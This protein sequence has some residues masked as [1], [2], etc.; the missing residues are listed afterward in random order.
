MSVKI[1][2]LDQAVDLL[3]EAQFY[4]D[5]PGDADRIASYIA[6]RHGGEG[7]YAGSFALT[8]GERADGIRVFT[9]E[10]MTSASARHIIGEEACRALRK[11]RGPKPDVKAVFKAADRN[12]RA[13]VAGYMD[14]EGHPGFF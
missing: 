1:Q 11:L 6:R 13:Q 14:A 8:R 10:R 3:A 5:K 2:T 7:A 4:G 12:M 9:G